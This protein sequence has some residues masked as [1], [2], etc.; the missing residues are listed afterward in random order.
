LRCL[1]IGAGV[2][3]A[4]GIPNPT[5]WLDVWSIKDGG[6]DKEKYLGQF[7]VEIWLDKVPRTASNWLDFAK[8]GFYTGLAFHR[9]IHDFMIQ[10]GC[11][12]TR[13][14]SRHFQAGMGTPPDGNFTN[15]VTGEMEFRTNGGNIMDEHISKDENNIA[16]LSMANQGR[17]N[18]GG[19]QWFINLKHNK[20]LDWWKPSQAKHVVF[21]RVIEGWEVIK[22][23][24]KAR[25]R[26]DNPTQ[27]TTI[28]NLTINWQGDKPGEGGFTHGKKPH[29]QKYYT[30]D[31][32]PMPAGA[33]K[34]AAIAAPDD[35]A[36]RASEI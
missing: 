1:L 10:T 22:K 35:D 36:T 7:Q 25:V 23:I 34:P 16:T 18:S 6:G 15:L 17:P 19:S 8:S 2:A 27:P 31:S 29:G 4:T 24:E 30:K 9:I 5:A 3:F 26:A 14:H 13:K 12:N 28:R 32:H 33:K 20:R 11:P 21:G